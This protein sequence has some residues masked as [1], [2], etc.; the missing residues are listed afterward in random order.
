MSP[1]PDR[2][3]SFLVIRRDNI[4]DLVCTT[5]L[6]R[7]LRQ[8]RPDA[9]ID[10]LVNSYNRPVLDGNPDLDHIYAYT[11]AKHRAPGESAAGVLWRRL[12][13]LLALRRQAYDVVI[14][15]NRRYVPR[16]ARLARWLKP[17]MTIGYVPAGGAAPGI[18]RPLPTPADDGRHEVAAMFGLLTP[19]AIAGEPPPLRLTAPESARRSAGDR[20]AAQPWWQAQRHTVAIHISA[21]KPKQR[22]PAE[23]FAALMHELHARYRLQFLLFWSPGDTDNRLHPGD[24]AKAAAILDACRELPVLAYP[25]ADLTDLIGGLAICDR[26]ICSDGGAMHIGA[27]L[28]LPIVCFFGNSAASVWHPWGVRHQLLQTP[29]RDVA[30]ITV[31]DAVAAFARLA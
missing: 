31:A 29:S 1:N 22:W 13:L 12:G 23:R 28:G 5:P 6:I 18:D 16:L 2:P 26:M 24:D 20:L 17:G 27:A 30:D 9:R 14:L 25:T 11:K 7:A 15:A 10:A 4:G 19:L 21:R 3:T 8:A